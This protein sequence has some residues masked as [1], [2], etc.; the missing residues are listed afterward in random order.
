MKNTASLLLLLFIHFPSLSS[1]HSSSTDSQ[2]ST[3]HSIF[4]VLPKTPY[5]YGM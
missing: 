3:K 2:N 1:L 4:T 5:V